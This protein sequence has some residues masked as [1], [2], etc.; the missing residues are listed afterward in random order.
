MDI[1]DI[2]E[3]FGDKYD[4]AISEMLEY[5]DKLEAEGKIDGYND[6]YSLKR[7]RWCKIWNGEGRSQKDFGRC[8]GIK[9]S[10]FSKNTTDDFGFCHVFYNTS[11]EC[12]AIEILDNVE[13]FVDGMMVFPANIEDVKSAVG[14]FQKEDE[15]SL[16]NVNKS[17][18][19]YAPSGKMESILFGVSGYYE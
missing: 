9:K 1:D 2:H 11:D 15:V 6:S 8:K 14:E 12:E 17:V 13:V 16:V 4:D 7:S 10:K 5:V 19:I 18:G 3:K